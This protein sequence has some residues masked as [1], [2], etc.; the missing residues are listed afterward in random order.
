MNLPSQLDELKQ[1]RQWLGYCMDWRPD[2][3]PPGYSKPPVSPLDLSGAGWTKPER[4]TDFETA[5]AT[6][7]KTSAF[8]GRSGPGAAPGP[9]PVAGIGFVLAGGYAVCDLDHVRDPQTGKLAPAAQKIIR[10]LDSYTEVSPSGDGVHILTHC[11]IS[12]HPEGFRISVYL[13][14]AGHAWTPPA[15]G[16]TWA[17]YEIFAPAQGQNYITITGKV[18]TNRPIRHNDKLFNLY[19]G[20]EKLERSALESVRPA[21]R[22]A[23][24][25]SFPSVDSR[26]ETK[27]A[28]SALACINPRRL[29][30]ADW[31]ACI[32]AARNCGVSYDEIERWSA[33]GGHNEWHREGYIARRWEYFR[34]KNG[35]PSGAVAVLIKKAREAGGD[36]F[37]C[38]TPEERRD[39]ALKLHPDQEART[40]WARNKY[41]E[42]ERR[43]YGRDL[44]ADPFTS[45]KE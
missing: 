26:T 20:F 1:C 3:K 11:D 7:G 42:E 5:A 14:D 17:H 34:L 8:I 21:P 38:L 13:D 32:A 15:G 16:Q 2:K 45:Y 37:A 6:I 41:T 27:I 9:L 40:A 35:D 10:Y 36:P 24:A 30:F 22:T 19:Q 4:W 28:A 44:H 31:A 33:Q 39:Y 25:K 43:Q 29:Y 12:K 18:L 23:D